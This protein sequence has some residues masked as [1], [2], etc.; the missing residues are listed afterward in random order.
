[1]ALSLR[2][3]DCQLLRF[4]PHCRW[5][6][7][8][9]GQPQYHTPQGGK[10]CLCHYGKTSQSS[11]IISTQ[12]KALHYPRTSSIDR[13]QWVK[14]KR[15]VVSVFSVWN[16][17]RDLH[18]KFCSISLVF[19]QASLWRPPNIPI[20]A[21]YYN[22]SVLK[23]IL[24]AISQCMLS[25]LNYPVERKLWKKGR[26]LIFLQTIWKSTTMNY[27]ETGKRLLYI[28]KEYFKLKIKYS[29]SRSLIVNNGTVT[30]MYFLLTKEKS[31]IEI[32]FSILCNDTLPPR[33]S[34]CP[35]GLLS[36]LKDWWSV[37]DSQKLIDWPSHTTKGTKIV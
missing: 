2:V 24:V 17:Y 19:F 34:I 22:S 10:L 12:R 1:M 36:V 16:A 6:P 35:E 30:S 14:N 33:D 8:R 27:L 29:C 20:N 3:P 26:E 13:Q 7:P 15:N 23:Q 9:T 5:E 32:S 4:L 28:S 31:Y 21:T 11:R 18:I 37:P 25:A